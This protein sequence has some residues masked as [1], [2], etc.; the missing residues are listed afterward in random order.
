MPYKDPEKERLRCLEK[1][2]NARAEGKVLLYKDW[3]E[4][5]KQASRDATKTYRDSHKEERLAY[6]RMWW[7][8]TGNQAMREKKR[9]FKAEL[10]K[11][12]G[13]AC[14]LCGYNKHLAAL[15]FDHLD[16]SEK[17][18]AVASLTTQC[19]FDEARKEA[20]KC[21]LLCSNCH[22]EETYGDW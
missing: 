11:E 17:I 3:P 12:F 18:S 7:S 6:S 10:V 16:P 20:Q 8:T 21:R 14:I 22:R 5:R 9:A 2:R 4:E 13:G 15:D 19:R 1:S